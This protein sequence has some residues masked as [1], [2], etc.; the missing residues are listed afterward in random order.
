MLTLKIQGIEDALQ[1]LGKFSKGVKSRQLI[2]ASSKAA[3][4]IKPDVVAR[5]PRETGTLAKAFIVKAKRTKD[6]E[7][8]YALVGANKAI[9]VQVASNS[10]KV[11]AT[12]RTKKDGTVKVTGIKKF[13]KAVAAGTRTEKRKPSRYLHLVEGGTKQGVRARR[14]M[15]AAL[16][17]K[18]DAAVKAFADKLRRGIEEE[19]AKARTQ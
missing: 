19:A 6:G 12:F 14:F 2:K 10:R 5:A 13:Q 4:V 18:G 7:G 17:A 11:L 16:A 15:R 1:A 9:S 3:G 8:A